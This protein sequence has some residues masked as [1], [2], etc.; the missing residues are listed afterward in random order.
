M[1]DGPSSSSGFSTRATAAL[2]EPPVNLIHSMVLVDEQKTHREAYSTWVWLRVVW[3]SVIISHI[4]AT[5]IFLDV[6]GLKRILCALH[7]SKVINFHFRA[8]KPRSF[9]SIT[10]LI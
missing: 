3:R 6:P 10:I 2:Q 4:F 9:D 7:V 8:S 5:C 1:L